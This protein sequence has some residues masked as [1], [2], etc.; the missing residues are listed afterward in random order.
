M[1]FWDRP[2]CDS[3]PNAEPVWPAPKLMTEEMQKNG[4]R[5]TAA[6]SEAIGDELDRVALEVVGAATAESRE[7]RPIGD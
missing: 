5:W 4:D 2:P 7:H 6:L 1:Q 3:C